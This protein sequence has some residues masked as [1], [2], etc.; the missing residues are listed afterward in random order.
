M[1]FGEFR[2]ILD[3]PLTGFDYSKSV[4]GVSIFENPA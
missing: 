1:H 2:L 3:A 4:G